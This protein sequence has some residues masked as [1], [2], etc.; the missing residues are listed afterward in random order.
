MANIY[1]YHGIK[2]IIKNPAYIHPQ[3]VIIGNVG[4][5]RRVYIGPNAVLREIGENHY[6]RRRKRSKKTVRFMFL[7][8]IFENRHIL[9]NTARL[10]IRHYY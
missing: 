9:V 8:I 7:G 5:W 1:S 3:A 10:F 2:P 6:Q 4:N